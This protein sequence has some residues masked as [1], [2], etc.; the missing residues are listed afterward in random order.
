MARLLTKLQRLY[1]RALG[2]RRTLL[3]VLA[4]GLCL[5]T[6][7]TGHVHT[8]GRALRFNRSAIPAAN[9][10]SEGLVVRERLLKSGRDSNSAPQ[11]DTETRQFREGRDGLSGG[12]IDPARKDTAPVPPTEYRGNE[13]EGNGSR[14]RELPAGVKM[15]ISGINATALG[16]FS[17]RPGRTE[18]ALQDDFFADYRKMTVNLCL[19]RCKENSY[20][21]AGLEYGAECYCGPEIHR[22]S[23]L[24][25]MSECNTS[26]VADRTKTCGGKLRAFIYRME[27]PSSAHQRPLPRVKAVDN[28]NKGSPNPKDE[29][30]FRGCYP[31]AAD[32]DKAFPS[33]PLI[34]E[35]QTPKKCLTHCFLGSFTF[36]VLYNT[37]VCRCADIGEHFH[38]TDQV[39]DDTCDH[40]C[41]DDRANSCGSLTHF[42]AYRTVIQ[43]IRCTKTVLLPTN[44]RPLTALVSFPGS[45]NTW[46]RHLIETAT[47]IYTGSFYNDGDLFNKGFRGEKE[48][49]LKRN[50]VAVK[51][52]RFDRPHIE[53][54][55]SAILI[56]RNPYN[57]IVS[58]HNRKHGGHTGL[59]RMTKYQS[60]EWVDF[61]TGKS[62]TWTNTA[63]NWIRYCKNLLIVYYE[64]LQ[65][66]VVGQ[67]RRVLEFLNLPVSQERMYCLEANK[68]GKF[69]RHKH[70]DF[71][72]YTPEMRASINLYIQTVALSLRLYNKT[73]LP[74]EYR[75]EV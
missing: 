36:A 14:K 71:D 1:R 32:F 3:L 37:T 49:W 68:D 72:P 39:A 35:Q 12:V 33:P 19:R 64:D 48:N 42:S 7:M 2:N 24:V 73:A 18:R 41:P 54:F 16:C 69:K 4:L 17:D 22:D 23:D 6:Y 21:Y 62:Q 70:I 47:G 25:P 65:R 53:K 67:I 60:Q 74:E 63:M 58:E 26:C 8:A 38:L 29:T 10:P 11:S 15:V 31:M 66:D 27:L 13:G 56:I 34:D 40:S 52:H 57:A 9:P 20:E 50:T 59:A 46:V 75:P 55:D 44:S 5:C 61:V 43:D 51:S 28:K 45:G 30:P